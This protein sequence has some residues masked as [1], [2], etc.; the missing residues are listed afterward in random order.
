MVF[1]HP[2]SFA[3][4]G[5]LIA[6]VQVLAAVHHTLGEVASSSLE[7]EVFLVR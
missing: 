2:Y 3:A 7:E 6:A 4:F 1:V 5:K